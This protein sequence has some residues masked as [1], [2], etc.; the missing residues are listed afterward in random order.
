MSDDINVGFESLLLRSTDNEQPLRRMCYRDTSGGKVL[1]VKDDADYSVDFKKYDSRRD[2]YVEIS[3]KI[4]R[5]AYWYQYGDVTL[6][7]IAD[8]IYRH[9]NIIALSNRFNPANKLFVLKTNTLQFKEDDLHLPKYFK[10]DDVVFLEEGLQPNEVLIGYQGYETNIFK[11]CV[12]GLGV[13]FEK[14]DENGGYL[15]NCLLDDEDIPKY[16]S[17]LKFKNL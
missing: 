5:K 16:V 2:F 9:A 8:T 1:D 13:R 12:Y 3:M 10:P 15:A 14:V 11:N 4:L 17:V 7:E 6:D